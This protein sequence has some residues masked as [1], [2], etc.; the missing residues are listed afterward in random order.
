[1][2]V[3]ERKRLREL[4]KIFVGEKNWEGIEGLR[5]ND[6]KKV[7]VAALACTMLLGI[8]DFHFDNVKT[9]LL[10][11]RAFHRQSSDTG[12]SG[13]RSG[14]S[15]QGGPVVLSWHDVLS[16]GRNPHDG[17]NVVVHEFAHALDGL[18]GEMGGHVVFDDPAVTARWNEVIKREY[19]QL[20][21]AADFDYPSIL[22]YYGATNRAEFFAVASETFFEEPELLRQVKPELFELFREYYRV[23]PSDWTAE[24]G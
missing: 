14:E 20:R 22:D 6:E 23:D 24:L 5:I 2:N 15:W 11:P 7:T 10:F 1:M 18:D 9:I 4:T 17:I 3:L 21:V 19:E 8:D 12:E 16:G 13:F